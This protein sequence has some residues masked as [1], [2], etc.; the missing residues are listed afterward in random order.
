MATAKADSDF[1]PESAAVLA[2][3][4]MHPKHGVDRDG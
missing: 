1:L 2:Y 4:V 3:A